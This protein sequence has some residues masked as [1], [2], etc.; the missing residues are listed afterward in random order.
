M[1]AWFGELAKIGSTVDFIL[2][3]FE[4][5]YHSES[6]SWAWC[7]SLSSNLS[8]LATR[9]LR[10]GYSSAFTGFWVPEDALLKL[11]SHGCWCEASTHVIQYG[12]LSTH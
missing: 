12:C 9:S 5:G 11:L 1:S 3:D 10:S 6:Y 8:L 4:M 7:S 2:S